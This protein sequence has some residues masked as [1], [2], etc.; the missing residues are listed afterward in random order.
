M[1]QSV[2]VFKVFKV[3]KV[4]KVSKMFK[5]FKV[6]NVFNCVLLCSIVFNCVRCLGWTLC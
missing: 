2:H 5:V 4:F 6:F 3:P 1:C